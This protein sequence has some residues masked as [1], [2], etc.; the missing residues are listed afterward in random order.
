MHRVPA[1]QTGSRSN[2]ENL[3]KIYINLENLNI[4][5]DQKIL[6]H[7]VFYDQTYRE[8]CYMKWVG[9]N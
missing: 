3:L 2:S 1:M 9:T 4:Q 5:Y 6:Y 7:D 8:W